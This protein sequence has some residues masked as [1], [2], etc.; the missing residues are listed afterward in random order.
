MVGA[1][2]HMRDPEVDVVDDARQLV[3]G[4]AVGPEELDAL[5]LLRQ[6]RGRLAVALAAVAL[7]HRPLVP[8]DPQPAEVVE[9]RLFPALDV[10]GRVGVVDPQQE[11]AAEV[12]VGDRAEGVADVERARRA[13][14][15][16]DLHPPE[17]RSAHT[18]HA[19]RA[20]GADGRAG[21]AGTS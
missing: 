10:P 4:A 16:A 15:E 17:S 21:E 13:R 1:A 9:D 8:V 5:E 7:A 11:G 19:F 14:R 6:A 12:A 20:S 18:T 3:G 2:D